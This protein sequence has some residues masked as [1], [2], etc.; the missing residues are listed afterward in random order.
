MQVGARY[1]DPTTGSF[2]TRDKDINQLAYIYCDNDPVNKV[3]PS[4]HDPLLEMQVAYEKKFFSI[5]GYGDSFKPAGL[6]GVAA[7]IGTIIENNTPP[8]TMLHGIGGSL[9]G[10]GM[11]YTGIGL[12]GDGALLAGTLAPV[13]IPVVVTVGVVTAVGGAYEIV[14]AWIN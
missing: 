7:G 9:V 10:T 4:G 5:W 13:I 8:G 14:H 11:I 12:V 2:L 6:F 3:D 1:Y